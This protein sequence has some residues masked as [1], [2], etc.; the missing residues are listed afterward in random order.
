MRDGFSR[1]DEG[2]LWWGLLPKL[3]THNSA[4]CLQADLRF[5]EC[6]LFFVNTVVK[7]SIPI[8]ELWPKLEEETER[9][10]RG[11]FRSESG[12]VGMNTFSDVDDGNFKAASG[13]S[14][15]KKNK[16]T[17]K[18]IH[19]NKI[20]KNNSNLTTKFALSFGKNHTAI[21]STQIQ[22]SEHAEQLPP[23][24]NHEER[25]NAVNQWATA[26][27]V[28]AEQ[29]RKYIESPRRRAATK[30]PKKKTYNMKRN[31]SLSPAVQIIIS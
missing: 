13:G 10:F 25:V 3:L 31:L 11:G 26:N 22:F 23:L 4:A 2:A 6:L 21:S 18:I 24:R 17:N 20:N 29:L 5:F 16:E 1:G 14:G 15:E 19:S 27:L 12:R 9:I 28:T 8:E 30:R 7:F